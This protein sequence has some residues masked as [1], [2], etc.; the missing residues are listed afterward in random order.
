MGEELSDRLRI[1]MKFERMMGH[2]HEELM[3]IG[4]H[5]DE[6]PI[7][8]KNNSKTIGYFTYDHNNKKITYTPA[9]EY[10]EKTNSQ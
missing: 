5:P 2:T 4:R 8:N 1:S 10:K 3:E 6:A 7:L 9:K